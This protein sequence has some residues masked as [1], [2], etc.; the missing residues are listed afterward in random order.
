MSKSATRGKIS[1]LELFYI[2]FICRIVVSLTSVHSVS[3]TEINSQS[4]ISY[5]LAM[6]LTVVFS[7]PAIFCCKKGKNPIDVKCVSKLY[8]VYFLIVASVSVSRFSY[9]AS[10]T[11]NPETQGWLFA[12]I[13][14]TCAFYGAFLG[15]EALS[16]FS[17]FCFVLLSLAVVSVILCNFNTFR[18]INLYPIITSSKF[19]L[20]KNAV[21]FASNTSEIAMF[22]AIFPKV[23]VR[24][25]R[26]YIRF[27]C[28][29]FLTVFILLYFAIAVMGKSVVIR[30]FPFYSF[31]QISKFGTFERLD[32]LHISFWIMGVFVKAVTSLYCASSCVSKK[33]KRSFVFASSFIVFVISILMLKLSDGQGVNYEFTMILFFVFCVIIPVSTLVFKKKNYGDELVKAY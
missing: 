30:N 11:L 23:N 32:V 17:A 29:S 12:L 19:D 2:L 21:V 33:P 15:I 20:I 1:P 5:I 31:F 25:E 14:C 18:E 22:L 4:L 3:K 6:F 10:T 26:S 28:L 8:Y 27:I 9:F 24:C 13:V 7:L 16:R